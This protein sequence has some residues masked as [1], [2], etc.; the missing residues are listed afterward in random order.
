MFSA[1]Q[2][3]GS[4]TCIHV[5]PPFWIPFPLRSPQ[6]IQYSSQCCAVLCLVALLCPTLCN[7]MGWGLPSSS[8]HGDSPGKNTGVGCH[9]L[10][11]GDLPNSG[12]KPRFP[13]L[14]VDSLPSEPPG[15]PSGF[16]WPPPKRTPAFWAAGGQGHRFC[17]LGV[18]CAMDESP[19]RWSRHIYTSVCKIESWGEL[20]CS[21]GGSAQRFVM[22]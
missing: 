6:S 16:P 12:T 8:V 22:T 15:K 18:K 11:Q 2:R 3:S 19:S 9:A 10:L 5:Y 17:L 7:P 20:L 13:A 21:T 4:V 14:Q 1:I